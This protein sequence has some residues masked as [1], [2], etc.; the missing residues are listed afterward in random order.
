MWLT[1]WQKK[2]DKKYPKRILL[3][4]D[5]RKL[6]R[7]ERRAL[8]NKKGHKYEVIKR[9]CIQTEI[10]GYKIWNEFYELSPCGQLIAKVGYRWDGPSGPTIDTPSFM[11]GSLWH[12]LLWQM[13]RE[14]LLPEK[15][16]D[17]SNDLFKRINKEDGM[18]SPRAW[19]TKFAVSTVGYF[20]H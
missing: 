5:Y 14:E 7:K 16:Y 1:N 18:W 10:T 3:G 17:Y 15:Y 11:R 4:Q 13:M 19:Y 6:S 9:Q 20:W 2:P 12:D 8:K